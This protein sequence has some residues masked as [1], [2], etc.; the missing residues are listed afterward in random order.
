[1]S[2]MI[3]TKAGLDL[4][5][6]A[7]ARGESNYWI[8]YYGLAF[9]PDKS[10]DPVKPEMTRLTETGDYIY[11]IWQGD[12]INGYA[13]DGAPENAASSL[14]G[15]TLYSKGIC[16]NYR[17]VLDAD[18]NNNLVSWTSSGSSAG[19]N[20]FNRTPFHIYR[21]NRYEVDDTTND[22]SNVKSEIP[23]PAPLFYMNEPDKDNYR[24]PL[25]P[26]S[27]GTSLC[28]KT[29]ASGYP[30][31][32]L[33][34]T[35]T[36]YDRVPM[37]S[38]DARFYVGDGVAPTN[39]TTFE[40][41]CDND[42][43]VWM[44]STDTRPVDAIDD[45]DKFYN[46]QYWKMRSVSNFNRFHGTVS[47]EG[48]GVSSVSSCHNMSRAT[49]LFP[50]SYYTVIND[51][52]KTR[53][54]TEIN[55][56]DANEEL[57]SAIKFT[58]DL[59]LIAKD[60]NFSFADYDNENLPD[61]DIVVDEN[62]TNLYATKYNS[63][64]FNRIG[65]YAVPMTIHRYA[66]ESGGTSC[67]TQHVQFEIDGDAEPILFAVADIDIFKISDNDG[68]NG[69]N[70]FTLDFILNM[71]GASSDSAVIRDTAI[72]Y[73][74]Y[75]NSAITWYENQLL[76]SA[77]LSEAVTNLQIELNYLKSQMKE[78]GNGSCCSQDLD[79]SKYALKN[80]THDYLKNLVDGISSTG[81]LRG[82]NTVAEGPDN[83]VLSLNGLSDKAPSSTWWSYENTDLALYVY[84]VGYLNYNNAYTSGSTLDT[85]EAKFT[86]TESITTADLDTLLG[87]LGIEVFIRDVMRG[88][89]GYQRKNGSNIDVIDSDHVYV[90]IA[91]SKIAIINKTSGTYSV[92]SGTASDLN[93]YYPWLRKRNA[94]LIDTLSG[95]YFVGDN[96]I[97]LG[98]DTMG[99]G[100][101]QLV[102][103][104]RAYADKMSH[105]G[106]LTGMNSMLV[107]SPYTTL[108]NGNSSVIRNSD[109]VLG[110]G[111]YSTISNAHNS[112]VN[113]RSSNL[114]CTSIESSIINATTVDT[115]AGI[116]NSIIE[117]GYAKFN[118][119]YR[120]LVLIGHNTSNRPEFNGVIEDSMVLGSVGGDIDHP[121]RRSMLLKPIL[122]ELEDWELMH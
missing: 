22:T 84:S 122:S 86:E 115:T 10:S 118:G 48:Y 82:I 102:Q 70:K 2:S 114:D 54:E 11:N 24:K 67:D 15:L 66:Q 9:V 42:A 93:A 85:S 4:L 111:N 7:Y 63:F 8:G 26:D 87:K 112:I 1:M 89:L 28:T 97:V 91:S 27:F 16:S 45:K 14:F 52:G 57:A 21:G 94:I 56:A 37:V 108:F 99:A 30:P 110:A 78:S 46:R 64:K 38:S 100:A 33:N 80:H 88:N 98:E 39:T 116:S 12:L 17:Y 95:D 60:D 107:N 106:I 81:A 76:A 19:E 121:I 50:I 104:Q 96:T 47:S 3:I 44:N 43:Y 6:S 79:L 55:D 83:K 53:A 40:E 101:N 18:G 13:T 68:T 65:I 35:C 74:M 41:N 31:Y 109:S 119:I 113:A 92:I 29:G 73:N 72:F 62:G 23:V 25:D 20:T 77:G 36:K 58:I 51:N 61:E 34:T 117:S 120:S 105:F 90:W 49:K 32:P 75:E 103:G 59:S 69:L 71:E 5:G